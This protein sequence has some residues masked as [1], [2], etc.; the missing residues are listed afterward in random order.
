MECASQKNQEFPVFLLSVRIIKAINITSRDSLSASDCYVTLSLPTATQE[1]FRTQTIKNSDSPVWNETF[2]YRIQPEIKNIIRLELCDDDPFSKDDSIFIVYFD[3]TRVQPGDT[4]LELFCFRP[5]REDCYKHECLEVEFRLAA[6]SG[7]AEQLIS[8]GVLVARELSILEVKIDEVENKKLLRAKKTMV[9]T[10]Q[11]SYEGTQKTT[12]GLN[13][14]RFHCVKNWEPILKVKLQG[15]EST[16]GHDS[17]YIL[18]VPLKCLPVG[19]EIKL[20]LPTENGEALELNLQVIGWPQDLDVR[21]GY[22][23]CAEEQDFLCKRKK[24]VA[25]ALS[26]LFY[27]RRNL[28]EH[29]VPVIAVMATGGG[30]RAMVALYGHLLAL[31]KLKILDCITYITTASGSTW[32]LTDLYQ[33]P[34]WSHRSLGPAIKTAKTRILRSKWD[35][36]SIDKLKYYRKQLDERVEKGHPISFATLW[37]LVQASFLNDKPNC[38]KLTEQRKALNEGQNPLPIYTA[39]NVKDKYVSTFEFREWIEFNPYEVGFQKYGAYIRTE[40]FDSQFYMGKLV[41]RFPESRICYLEG[42][43]TNIFSRNLLDGLYWSSSPEEFWDRWVKDMAEKDEEHNLKDGYTTVYKPPCSS[44]GNLC[45]I[46]ND[47]LTDRPLKGANCNFLEGLEFTYDYLYK[48]KFSEWKDTVFDSFPGKLT[49][50]EKSLCLID[51][52]YFVNNSGP[53]LLKPERNVDVFIAVDYDCYNIFKQTEMMSKYCEVQGIPFPKINLTEEDRKN[54]KECYVFSDEDPKAP[55]VIYFPL[56]NHTF[57]DYKA[58]GVKRMPKE[59]CGGD[60]TIN[61]EDSPYATKH[62]TYSADNFD[63]LL[64]LATYN[65]LCSKELI[66]QSIEK[67]VQKKQTSGL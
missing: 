4:V 24:V 34:D 23:L 49:P 44:S 46:F 15:V 17:N 21:L 16:G 59:M 19:Q 60:I 1:K 55:I 27:L 41:K 11:E 53:P 29:E 13:C 63:K 6:S 2:Y 40:D 35:V 3:V 66:L 12:K 10:V 65:V 67:A 61:G 18:I 50:V 33:D 8:N 51:V 39:I 7:S 30:V 26:K 43:W 64:N 45:E 36:I 32:T 38:R 22:K 48:N 28:L 5:E 37:G 20:A 54:P 52:G 56:I 58:P 25:D 14:F 9:L 42:I 31:Q 62:V 47:I 57:R